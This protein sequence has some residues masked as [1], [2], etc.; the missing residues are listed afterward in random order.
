MDERC[1]P[2]LFASCTWERSRPRSCTSLVTRSVTATVVITLRVMPVALATWSQ[3]ALGNAL[4]R[5]DVLRKHGLATRAALTQI[6][7]HA[8]PSHHRLPRSPRRRRAARRGLF[9]ARRRHARR[10]LSAGRPRRV[11]LRQA[12]PRPAGR[13]ARRLARADRDAGSLG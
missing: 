13:R 8:H 2:A 4:A 11:A 5:E 3:V 10:P 7:F 6:L 12:P 9:P 1:L